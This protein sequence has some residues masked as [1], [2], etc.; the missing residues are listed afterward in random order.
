[1]LFTLKKENLNILKFELNCSGTPFLRASMRVISNPTETS[2][3]SAKLA[4]SWI[5][6]TFSAVILEIFSSF[7]G[8]H[9]HKGIKKT[10]RSSIAAL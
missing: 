5:S 8:E 1:M 2:P 7:F 3:V 10:V 4:E 9:A 6:L